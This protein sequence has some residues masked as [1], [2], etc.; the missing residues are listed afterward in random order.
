MSAPLVY[1]MAEGC[2]TPP[3]LL[4]PEPDW[5]LAVFSKVAL[6]TLRADRSRPRAP[7]N[8]RTGEPLPTDQPLSELGLLAYE[9]I[10]FRLADGVHDA[11]GEQ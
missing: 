11:A 6:S 2:D 4:A 3:Q 5:P 9:V 1:A 8:R 7:F 10:E